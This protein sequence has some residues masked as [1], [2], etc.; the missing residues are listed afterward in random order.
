MEL[1]VRINK[2]TQLFSVYFI[3][4]HFIKNLLSS[5][6]NETYRQNFFVLYMSLCIE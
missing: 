2:L 3:I 6:R 5:L 4:P 1:I